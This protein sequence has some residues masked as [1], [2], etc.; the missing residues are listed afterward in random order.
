MMIYSHQ[1]GESSMQLRRLREEAGY[2]Q[3]D[4]AKKAGVTQS[5]I[6]QYEGGLVKRPSAQYAMSISSALGCTIDDLLSCQDDG[7]GGAA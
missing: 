1:G 6:S 2:S 3:A 4:L 5:I 7:K